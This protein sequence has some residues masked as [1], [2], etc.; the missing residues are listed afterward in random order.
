MRH[1]ANIYSEHR[2]LTI[3]RLPQSSVYFNLRTLKPYVYYYKKTKNYHVLFDQHSFNFPSKKKAFSENINN[4]AV[5]YIII[6]TTNIIRIP[7][8]IYRF[9]Q[10]VATIYIYYVYDDKNIVNNKSAWCQFKFQISNHPLLKVLRYR[11][12]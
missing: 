5:V 11:G 1:E 3:N 6:C 7:I 10:G 2:L 12:K 4:T 8:I 9:A